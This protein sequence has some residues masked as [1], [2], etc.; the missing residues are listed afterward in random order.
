MGVRYL[1]RLIQEKSVD[2]VKRIHFEDLRGK[3]I[4]VDIS[5]YMYRFLA[6]GA[7]LENMY[8]LASIFRYYDINAIFVF[9]GPP[10]VQKTDVIEIR[11]KKKDAAKKQY[12]S[13]EMILRKKKMET[14]IDNTEILEIEETMTQLKK[15]FIHIRDIDIINV[16]D[17]L[18][19]FGFTIVDAEG[20]ADALCAKLA[21][22]RRV[23][24]CM[25]DDTDMF[26]Y[27]CPIVLRHVSL[28]NHSAVSYNMADILADMKITQD[29]FKMMCIVNG[30]DYNVPTN[31]PTENETMKNR[32]VTIYEQLLEF[33]KLSEKERKKYESGFYEWLETKKKSN[34]S[35][36]A[37]LENETMF[38]LSKSGSSDHYKQLVVLNRKDINKSRIVEIMM[39]EDFIFIESKPDDHKIISALSRGSGTITSSP[40]YGVG[41]WDSNANANSSSSGLSVSSAASRRVT[42]TDATA[43]LDAKAAVNAVES[44]DINSVH[45]TQECKASIL[46]T[47]V[48]G[49]D[50][51]SLHELKKKINRSKPIHI[52]R[53]KSNDE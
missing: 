37:L 18:V 27:G 17:L 7:L 50:A 38:D 9:D 16:K 41:P 42:N 22:K 34:M 44:S 6:D 26:V 11:K 14:R 1:N 31:P 32:I 39:K 21:I 47:E 25:S 15:Q 3:K 33:K 52:R 2:S 53:K 12:A 13:M 10:P 8:L 46:A 36:I 4:A 45:I 23:F 20:E 5:I 48:Y 19:S 29:E 28:L 30:T 24:A 49:V 51:N 40:I 43:L 35:V